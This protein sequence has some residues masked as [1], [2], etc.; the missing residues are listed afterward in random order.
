MKYV[1]ADLETAVK[2]QFKLLLTV[3]VEFT[4]M[5]EREKEVKGIKKLYC[6]I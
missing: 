4:C 6:F 1:H 2:T 5:Y 3:M